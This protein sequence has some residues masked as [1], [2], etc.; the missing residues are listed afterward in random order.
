[1]TEE[2]IDVFMKEY[3]KPSLDLDWWLYDDQY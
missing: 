1:M 3:K 2:A